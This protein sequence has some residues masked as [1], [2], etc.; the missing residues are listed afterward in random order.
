[1]CLDSVEEIKLNVQAVEKNIE[2]LSC[3][4]GLADHQ[5]LTLEERVRRVETS[6]LS[7]AT[8]SGVAEVGAC[9][10]AHTDS[11]PRR[12]LFWGFCR[13][14]LRFKKLFQTRHARLRCPIL[15]GPRL[16]CVYVSGCTRFLRILGVLVA[17]HLRCPGCMVFT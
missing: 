5:I 1:M 17:W 13:E 9:L 2:S 11:Q 3:N 6:L 7:A 10:M 16:T 4:M 8:A 15:W 12:T 14:Q